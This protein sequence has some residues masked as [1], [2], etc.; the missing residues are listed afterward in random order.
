MACGK[1]RVPL[2][3][4]LASIAAGRYQGAEASDLLW[5][6]FRGGPGHPCLLFEGS[7]RFWPLAFDVQGSF[8]ITWVAPLSSVQGFFA[9]EFEGRLGGWVVGMRAQQACTWRAEATPLGSDL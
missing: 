8:G 3:D 2:S 7:D 5:R 4:V 1:Y 6:N 9:I